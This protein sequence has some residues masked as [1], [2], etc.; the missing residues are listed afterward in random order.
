MSFRIAISRSTCKKQVKKDECY[1]TV[2][3]FITELPALDLMLH[4]GLPLTLKWLRQN[5]SNKWHF[6]Q[7]QE[8]KEWNEEKPIHAMR[9]EIG[10]DHTTVGSETRKHCYLCRK[11]WF[12]FTEG[13]QAVFVLSCKNHPLLPQN[14]H[15]CMLCTHISESGGLPEVN[16]LDKKH[17]VKTGRCQGQEQ[18]CCLKVQPKG[19]AGSE[20]PLRCI[21]HLWEDALRQGLH[22]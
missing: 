2:Q 16:R 4:L 8:R 18:S 7:E 3:R 14:K 9:M 11:I 17:K 12:A 1:I 10:Y 13:E 5:A 22:R 6:T 19:D 15:W 20:Y 21:N